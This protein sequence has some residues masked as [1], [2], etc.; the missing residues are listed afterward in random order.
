MAVGV[1][2]PGDEETKTRKI[3]LPEE[4]AESS[5][6]GEIERGQKPPAFGFP[7]DFRFML[8]ST[9]L[10]LFFSCFHRRLENWRDENGSARSYL[11]AIDDHGFSNFPFASPFVFFASFLDESDGDGEE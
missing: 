7:G 6:L 11:K 2:N 1:G 10:P 4:W 9:L 3:R 8:S 5:L